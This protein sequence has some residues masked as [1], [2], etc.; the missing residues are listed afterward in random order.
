M[1]FP[2]DLTKLHPLLLDEKTGEPYLQLPSP[3]ENIR[4]T[5]P[6]PDDVDAIVSYLNDPRVYTHLVGPPSPYTTEDGITWVQR[7]TDKVQG[8]FHEIEYGN[9]Y[10]NGSPVCSIR[11]VQEDGTDILIGDI[12]LTREPPNVAWAEK[13]DEDNLIKP[14]GD[15]TI[16]WTIGGEP[17]LPHASIKDTDTGAT[18]P[19][20][21]YPLTIIVVAS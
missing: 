1:H 11:L 7:V 2:S 8:F 16:L 6:R 3:H 12:G 13:E 5:P 15:P 4:I 20:T 9:Q 14:T 21:I 18:Q 17:D 19:K 10:I